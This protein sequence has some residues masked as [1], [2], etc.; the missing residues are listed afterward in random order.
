MV[1]PLKNRSRIHSLQQDRFLSGFPEKDLI[2][3]APR[4]GTHCVLEYPK[5]HLIFFLSMGPLLRSSI[6][7]RGILEVRKSLYSITESRLISSFIDSYCHL[8]LYVF[9]WKACR[10]FRTFFTEYRLL[11]MVGAEG[12]EPSTSSAS[13]KHSSTELRAYSSKPIYIKYLDSTCQQALDHL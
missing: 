7:Y 2:R 12:I 8:N 10:L 1:R 11:L 3:R 13:R 6:V 4:D 9:I 5:N